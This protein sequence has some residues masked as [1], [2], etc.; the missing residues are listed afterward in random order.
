MHTYIHRRTNERTN[1]QTGYRAGKR[2]NRHWTD[3]ER[4]VENRYLRQPIWFRVKVSIL[5]IPYLKHLLKQLVLPL[6]PL[7][8]SYRSINLQSFSL[9]TCLRKH[10]TIPSHTKDHGSNLLWLQSHNHNHPR[11][12]WRG[13]IRFNPPPRKI[14]MDIWLRPYHWGFLYPHTTHRWPNIP[15]LYN[16]HRRPRRISRDVA[17]C[18]WQYEKRCFLNGIWYHATRK[19]GCAGLVR[20]ISYH[21]GR[22]SRRRMEKSAGRIF[23]FEIPFENKE[24]PEL[25]CKINTRGRIRLWIFASN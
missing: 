20:W 17:K 13:Q 8:K 7:N 2:T 19:S 4:S 14:P 3:S 12:R 24:I 18:Q 10:L 23:S 16:R 15:P 6:S 9:L 11:R 5:L 21:G 25:K 22:S 1:K